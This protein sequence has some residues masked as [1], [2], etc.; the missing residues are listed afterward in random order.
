MRT[1]VERRESGFSLARFQTMIYPDHLHPQMEVVVPECGRM[2]VQVDG[3]VHDLC[4]G[5]A[6][7]VFPN[8]LHSYVEDEDCRGLML[9]FSTS[10][11]PDL[12]VDWQGMRP[13]DPVITELC[14]DARYAA[15][16]LSA[17]I[18][19]NEL[20]REKRALVHLLVCGL[21]RDLPLEAAGRPLEGD[22]LF[23]ALSYMAENYRGEISLKQA[24]RHIGCNEYYLSHLFNAQLGM[25]FRQYV[26]LLRLDEAVRMLPQ[27]ELSMQQIADQC[28]FASLRSF[29]R[30]FKARYHCSPSRYRARLFAAENK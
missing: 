27:K 7:M 15:G 10:L 5:Q 4:A 21:L 26:S 22:L 28:G 13:A 16:R 25:G 14:E 2:K 19:G 8:R 6:L 1:M 11:L 24:A 23:N 17:M 29:D 3:E 9:I 30:V 12:G 20:T 18:P